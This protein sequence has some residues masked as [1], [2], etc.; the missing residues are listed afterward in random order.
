MSKW[1]K[2]IY[3]FNFLHPSLKLASNTHALQLVSLVV[4]MVAPNRH[5]GGAQ[6][7]LLLAAIFSLSF[8]SFTPSSLS[9]PSGKPAALHSD[10]R[11]FLIAD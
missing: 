10:E 9:S 1:Q 8:A 4:E 6:S 5:N 3:N 7:L 2:P 11:K